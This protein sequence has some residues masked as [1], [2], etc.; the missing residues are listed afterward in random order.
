MTGDAVGGVWTFAL[1]LARGLEKQGCE[2]VLAMMGPPMTPS[3]RAQVRRRQNITLVDGDYRLEWMN[4]PWADVD[5][6][7]DWLRG[8]A[9]HYRADIVHLNGYSHAALDWNLP[10]VIT[11]HS[12][13]CSWW[14]AVKGEDAPAVYD[15]YRRRVRLGLGAANLVTAPSQSMLEELHTIYGFFG[16]S[17]VI[18]NTRNSRNFFPRPKE[19]VIFS[20]GRIWDE[21][22]NIAALDA[23]ASKVEWPIEVAGDCQHPN[24]VSASLTNA[25]CLGRLGPK[26]LAA[27]VSKSAIFAL[28]ARYEPF[29]LSI[30]EA[31][32]SGCALVLG[33]IPSLRE[34][35]G[36]TAVFVDPQDHG[37]LASTL[38]E[39]IKDHWHRAGL[40]QR[41]HARA[42]DIASED[43]GRRYLAA[44]A[45]ALKR[46]PQG[47]AA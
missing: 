9:S 14:R 16:D 17:A 19:R 12:C 13:V 29:G 27:R 26:R 37:E 38:N 40:S 22:K 43:I 2:I 33:D 39:L 5:Q 18:P 4:D 46:Q 44:Y 23:I 31:G 42:K 8:L 30:L 41:A 7:G 15:E 20:A 24:G 11:A 10:V 28:P 6:A 21:A 1:E 35:W 32:L 45:S 25:L 34:I 36:N 47:V 3:Q